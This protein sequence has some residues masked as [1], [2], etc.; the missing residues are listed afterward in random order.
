MTII[1]N[2]VE[3]EYEKQANE[4]LSKVNATIIISFFG[5]G[6]HFHDDKEKRDIYDVTIKRNGKEYSFRFGQSIM[7]S[8]AP[9]ISAYKGTKQYDRLIG[10]GYKPKYPVN[11]D[12]VTL[13]KR[14]IPPTNYDI[15]ACLQKYEVGTFE[16]FCGD[17]GYD[18]DSR[19]AFETYIAVQKEFEGVKKVFGDVLEELAEIN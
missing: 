11:L 7:H 9:E 4:F 17:F 1:N 10:E 16:N 15:L 18:T 2:K 3:S 5:H 19:K 14:R 6:L 8:G 13:I 12:Q